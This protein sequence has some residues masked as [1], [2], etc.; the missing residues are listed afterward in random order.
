MTNGKDLGS[1]NSM[2][3]DQIDIAP[4]L[5]LWL[6]S[7]LLAAGAAACVF[8]FRRLRRRLSW[9]RALLIS[10]LRLGAFVFLAVIALNPFET[11]R[12]E[13]KIPPVVA[14]L[15][16]ASPSMALPGH[17]GKASRLEEAKDAL[18]GGTNP[19]LKEL[20]GKFE[21]RLF[22][23]GDSLQA[24]ESGDLPRINPGAKESDLNEALEALAG[25][26]HFALLFS[27]GNGKWGERRA[28]GLPLLVYPLGRR[29]EYR[30]VLIQSVK[31]PP[32]AFRGK[33]VVVDVA[34]KGY[35]YE[36]GQ[37]PVILK[38]GEKLL[39]AKNVRLQS[40]TGE[41][42]AGISFTPEEIGSYTLSVT[43]PPQA[44]E[45]VSGN[46]K[47]EFPLK[48][49]RDKIRVLMVSGSPSMSYRFLRAALKND[50]AIDLLSFVILR[51]PSNILNVP[52]QEQSLI[53]FPVDTL[54]TKD[55][56]NFDLLIFDNFLYRPFFR[57]Q[58]LGNIRD[59]VREGGAF[60][61]GGGVIFL[62]EGGYGGTP[63]EE[64]LPTR[65]IG[66]EGYRRPA[67]LTVR[68]S[69]AG[70]N[71]PIT[72]FS[73]DEAEQRM[74]W[75][76]M[77]P[78]AGFNPLESRN[79]GTVL[80]EGAEG[81]FWPV[82]TVG[83]YGKGRALV[84][85]TDDSW[86]WYMGM[87][88]KEKDH[89]AYLRLVERMVRWL[90]KDPGLDS[91][92]I[93][94]PEKRNAPGEEIEFRVKVRAEAPRAGQKEALSLS[95]LNP[96]GLK[97]ASQLKPGGQAGEF[98]AAFVAPRPG[99]YKIRIA[100]PKEAVEETVLIAD[101]GEEFDGAPNLD[102]LRQAASGS[103][104]KLVFSGDEI[105]REAEDLGK[106]RET[107]FLEEKTNSFWANPYFF[108]IVLSFL[109]L[110]WYLRRRWGL[111]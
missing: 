84:L 33:E 61:F 16:D 25:E 6:I 101:P 38:S 73:P 68:P 104:G 64:I 103:G 83:A 19:L 105:L 92:Q 59:F 40:G 43:V 17:S 100:S 88:A 9:K 69:R 75:Q 102:R 98:S 24:I 11:E 67:S 12:K 94:L 47:R 63:L 74:L 52:V 71:H 106:K 36:G 78:L 41:G 96:S 10:A 80:L 15:L 65:W 4:V 26:N 109:A 49:V 2:N 81:G 3:F 20:S 89:S 1:T 32:V 7:I 95:V 108:A 57:T 44:G 55:L 45:T 21:V 93:A 76:E 8:S 37:I 97:I 31:A 58:Y 50:P 35:G 48:V 86:K 87:V 60:A 77:P 13:V 14:V 39:A 23:L 5:P 111:I 34:V 62:G 107:R 90:T 54:F 18:L 42:T 29:E 56:K 28:G 30:D 85:A 110:E 27:D 72:R 51:L 82:L 99:A 70:A 53:P 22:Q 66:R 91:V 79:S 46:N